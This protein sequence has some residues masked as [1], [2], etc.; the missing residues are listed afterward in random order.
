MTILSGYFTRFFLLKNTLGGEIINRL[1]RKK[2][3]DFYNESIPFAFS[4][5]LVIDEN[6][7]KIGIIKRNEA[8]KRAYSV[9][10]DLVIVSPNSKPPVGKI[11][12]YSKYRYDQQRRQREIKKNQKTVDVKEVRLSPVIGDHD[13]DTKFNQA[14][15]FIEKGDKVK[16]SLRFRGRM[17]A[18][19]DQGFAVVNKFIE[20]FGDSIIVE[21]K[22]RM[23][24]RQLFA[25]IAPNR[26]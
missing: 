12:D 9:N 18:H 4:D 20:R 17:I 1:P 2:N 23:E 16:I 24:G 5:I 26:K 22:P 13:L 3:D 15:K 6:G 21:S 8:I 14:T 11:M 19:A 7:D 10:L 25:T